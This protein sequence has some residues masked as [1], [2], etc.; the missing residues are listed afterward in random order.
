MEKR[1]RVRLGE[2]LDDT[3]V[4]PGLWRGVRPRLQPFLE[5]FV[6]SLA[7]AAQR[8]NAPHY[9]QGLLSDLDDKN[10]AA[11]AYRHDQERPTLQKFR[12]QSLGDHGPLLEELVR[13][14][15]TTLGASDGVLVRDPSAFPKKGTESVGVPR[16]GCGRLGKLDNCQVGLY[17]GYVSRREHALVDVRL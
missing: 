3:E 9:V 1:F 4:P 2:L 7:R 11:I 15:G 5:P 16:Q 12:G 8:H 13:Q 17:L 14:V 6:A 10:A